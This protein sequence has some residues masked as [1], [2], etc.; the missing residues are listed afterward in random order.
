[1]KAKQGQIRSTQLNLACFA[2][3]ILLA[4]PGFFVQDSD[5]LDGLFVDFLLAILAVFCLSRKSKQ[6]MWS[7]LAGYML[8]LSF[9]VIGAYMNLYPSQS[10]WIP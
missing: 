10:S 5:S 6:A 7:Y 1:M 4:L 9:V 2:L 3:P 8:I